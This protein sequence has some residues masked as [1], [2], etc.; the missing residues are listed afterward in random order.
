M[1]GKKER[2]YISI[3]NT[4]DS[5]KIYVEHLEEDFNLT[6]NQVAEILGFSVENVQTYVLPYLLKCYA[7]DY[8]KEYMKNKRIKVVVSK[9]S[10]VKYINK[11][12]KLEEVKK[13]IAYEKED[14]RL[15][16]IISIIKDKRKLPS[17]FKYASEVLNLNFGK[18]EHDKER[19]KKRREKAY[20]GEIDTLDL[21]AAG[22]FDVSVIQEYYREQERLEARE[23]REFNIFNVYKED[24]Y[25]I[26]QIK[27]LIRLKHT[28]QV[29]RFL[30]KAASVKLRLNDM[31]VGSTSKGD[32]NIRYIITQ[33][34]LE[35]AK[36]D[37]Y[38]LILTN[39]AYNT[40]KAQAE[41]IAI[42]EGDI[43][44]YV[45]QLLML[46][47]EEYSKTLEKEEKNKDE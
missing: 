47:A 33:E 15:Q 23:L 30:D 39:Y 36:M 6:I 27:E 3:K 22:S 1:I 42:M 13:V 24:M 29:Y 19:D 11:S 26:R 32:R 41:V 10:L 45:L 44:E 17:F 7:D 40:I 35:E 34:D 14:V 5:K 20:R 4:I 37:C 8:V 25:S 9:N 12:L 18:T 28:Q 46:H 21:L 16:G 31:L 38:R 2:E 43:E